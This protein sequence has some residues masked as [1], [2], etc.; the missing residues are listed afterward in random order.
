M[1]SETLQNYVTLL[2]LSFDIYEVRRILKYM[3]SVLQIAYQSVT[4]IIIIYSIYKLSMCSEF[5]SFCY[6]DVELW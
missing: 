2:N 3:S 1:S 5:F 4:V 6:G